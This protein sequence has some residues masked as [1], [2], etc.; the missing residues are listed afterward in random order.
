MGDSGCLGV[1]AELALAAAV[2]FVFCFGVV[3]FVSFLV[4]HV[5]IH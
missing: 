1:L 4:H 5:S 3:A 2:L